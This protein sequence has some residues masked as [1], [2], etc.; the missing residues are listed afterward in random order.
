MVG[1]V[2][3][4]NTI[5]LTILSNARS[6]CLGDSRVLGGLIALPPLQ[7][8][9]LENMVCTLAHHDCNAAARLVIKVCD[10]ICCVTCLIT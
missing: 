1:M 6:F 5:H 4:L 3:H 8:W 2:F 7:C 10:C 9:S